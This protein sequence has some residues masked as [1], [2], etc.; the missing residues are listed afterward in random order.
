[1]KRSCLL[2]PIALSLGLSAM[3]VSADTWPTKPMKAIVP[4]AAGSVIDIVPRVVFAQLGKQLGQTIIVENRPGAGQTVGAGAVAKAGPDGYTLLVNSAAHAIAP[5]LHPNLGYDPARDFAAVAPL[6]V[7][8]FVLVVRSGRGIRT[9]RDLVAAA[10]AKPGAL[11]FAS[12]GVGSASHLSAERF[13][14]SAGVAAVHVPFKGGAEL[15]TEVLAGRI[16]F[17]FVA[18]GAVLRPIQDGT[19]AA[20][21]VNGATRSSALPDVPTLR[22]AGF[23]DAEYPMWFG[24][25]LPA[26][27]P[28]EIVDKLHRETARAL[29]EPAVK[30]RLASLGVDAMDLTR[31]EFHALVEKE[32][33]MNAALVNTLGLRPQ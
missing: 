22:E 32:I 12:P 9:P 3:D 21:G 23:E 27:T 1:M 31:A 17:A 15:I 2:L 28:R 25:F 20:L 26:R 10:S 18:L 11:N 4:I 13:R 24:L 19:I 29:Q 6:G 33:A 16:D 5:S 30:A 8:P 7:T 14:L